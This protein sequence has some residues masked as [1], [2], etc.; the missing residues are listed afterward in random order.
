[1]VY[2]KE[3]EKLLKANIWRVSRFWTISLIYKQCQNTCRGL[4]FLVKLPVLHN[5][6]PDVFFTLLNETNCPKLQVLSK[7]YFTLW[8]AS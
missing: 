8:L 1:M 2:L 3:E 5:T 7:L 4:L 6:P